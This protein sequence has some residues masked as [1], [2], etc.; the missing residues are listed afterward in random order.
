MCGRSRCTLGPADVA[1]AA[2]VPPSEL[3]ARW[4]RRERYSPVY[5]AMPGAWTPVV[6]VAGAGDGGG[7]G[8]CGGGGASG[9]GGGDAGGGGARED[10]GGGEDGGGDGGK[11]GAGQGGRLV[12]TMK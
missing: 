8:A 11:D 12:E 2:G 3:G 10:G 5:N 6:R 1:A 7:G 4:R 9:G